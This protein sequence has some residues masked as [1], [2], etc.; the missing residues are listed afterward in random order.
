MRLPATG[1]ELTL[2][3]SRKAYFSI[4]PNRKAFI[5][6]RVTDMSDNITVVNSDGVVVYTDA[7]AITGA[8]TFTKNTDPDVVYKLNLNGNFVAKV[9]NGTEEIGAGLDY[10]LLANGMLMLKNSYLRTLAAGEYTIRLTIKPMGENYP[11]N[12]GNDAPA[13][14]VLKLTVEKKKLTL[15]H[16]ESDGKI[17]DGK[18]IGTTTVNTDSDGALTFEYKEE[19]MRT[20]RRIPPK[21]RRMSESM[22]SASPQPRQTRSR[23]LPQR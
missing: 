16:K 22:S 8:Q 14:V 13:D 10:A 9:Y 21:R 18:S 5:Y 20:I 6:V 4:E 2:N 3:E 17:Y 1:R 19:R 15:G 11:D 7:E 23:R 12:S